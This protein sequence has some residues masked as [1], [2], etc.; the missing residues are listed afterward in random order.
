[1]LAAALIAIAEAQSAGP[2]A[3]E[4]AERAGEANP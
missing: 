1:M 3:A 2:A 4:E